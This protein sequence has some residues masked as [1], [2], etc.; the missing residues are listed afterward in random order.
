MKRFL[1]AVA[2]AA[3]FLSA[4]QVQ[5]Q[6]TKKPAAKPTNTSVAPATRATSDDWGWND[7]VPADTSGWEVR[8]AETAATPAAADPMMQ[9]S[10][11]MLAPGMNTAPYR[12][13]STDYNGRPVRKP[14]AATTVA[15]QPATDNS[16]MAAGW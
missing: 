7:A 1:S 8:G 4:P 2:I 12:G 5:A 3:A 16:T 13:V 6:T 10:G 11:V 14:A 9:S 15:A